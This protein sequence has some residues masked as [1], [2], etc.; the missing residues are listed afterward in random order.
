MLYND[1]PSAFLAVKAS[2]VTVAHRH[3][4]LSDEVSKVDMKM[5]YG[6]EYGTAF[7][8]MGILPYFHGYIR[9]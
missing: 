7:A 6:A 8:K 5:A 2:I 1:D 9:N 4:S 3:E